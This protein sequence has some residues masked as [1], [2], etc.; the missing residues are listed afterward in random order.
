MKDVKYENA[1]N[2]IKEA[3]EGAIQIEDFLQ[4]PELLVAKEETKKITSLKI[5]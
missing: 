5:N 1:P 3:I 4:P 2:D